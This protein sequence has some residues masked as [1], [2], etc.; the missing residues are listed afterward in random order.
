MPTK[1]RSALARLD[2][3]TAAVHAAEQ[4]ATKAQAERN[5]SG[6]WLPA[7]QAR[8]ASYLLN[9]KRDPTEERKLRD[10][11]QELEALRVEFD[12]RGTIARYADRRAVQRHEDAVD[13]IQAAQ[14]ERVAFITEHR[15][16]LQAEM[17][18]RSLT[19][20]DQLLTAADQLSAAAGQWQATARDWRAL[21]ERWPDMSPATI[22]TSPI[23]G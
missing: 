21:I 12:R 16:Q 14:T 19:A 5:A 18:A 8:L 6:R 7:A 2:E 3:L 4:H 15:D 1:T 9:D 22:P 10:E 20:R 11:V 17:L 23:S 13:A